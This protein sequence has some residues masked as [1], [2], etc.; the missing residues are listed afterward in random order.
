MLTTIWRNAEKICS[1]RE[2]LL[3]SCPVGKKRCLV[4]KSQTLLNPNIS[5]KK[6]KKTEEKKLYETIWIFYLLGAYG[7]DSL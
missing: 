4:L 3:N 7:L 1:Q 5:H 2:D 6:K